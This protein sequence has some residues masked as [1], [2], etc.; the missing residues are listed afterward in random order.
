[1]NISCGVRAAEGAIER[2]VING[3]V[4][5]ATIGDRPAAG[6][7]GSGIIDAVAELVKVGAVGNSGRFVR[8]SGSEP[9]APWHSRLKSDGSGRFVLAAT[10]EGE[11]AV[12]QKDIRQV[13]L[14]K[15][16][17]L[18]GILSLTSRLSIPLSDIDRIYIAGAF[19]HHVR[20]ESLARLGVFP[21]E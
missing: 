18:S 14:A 5:V 2:V 10:S 20:K 12:T 17:I 16:A 11:I 13:Q 4:E 21:A 1:M 15:G 19:G 9:P 8:L 7:C 6:I 3:S